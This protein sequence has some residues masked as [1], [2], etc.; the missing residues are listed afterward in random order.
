MNRRDALTASVG[1]LATAAGLSQQA[2]SEDT[3]LYEEKATCK[4]K[5]ESVRSEGQLCPLAPAAFH[6]TYTTYYSGIHHP[7]QHPPCNT[8]Q[9]FDGP[10]G[11]GCG[12]GGSG[13]GN[14]RP[15]KQ[16]ER[17]TH[18]HPRLKEKGMKHKPPIGFVPVGEPEVLKTDF[19]AVIRFTGKHPTANKTI[20]PNAKLFKLTVKPREFDSPDSAD[21]QNGE[22]PDYVGFETDE[23]VTDPDDTILAK[24]SDKHCYLVEYKSITYR[25]TVVR[26]I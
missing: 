16:E 22:V 2:R 10:N 20:K 4:C 18:N 19:V 24:E 25:I 3:I 7:S 23:S 6:G 12:C 14:Y 8:Y 1:L 9:F 11:L 17:K 13:C 21:W 5:E 15:Q 26:R